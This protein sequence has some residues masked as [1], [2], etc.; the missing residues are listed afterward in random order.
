MLGG[1]QMVTQSPPLAVPVITII[2]PSLRG[3]QI[4]DRDREVHGC[5]R[6]FTGPWAGTLGG[7]PAQVLLLGREAY[8]VS[9]ASFLR[10]Q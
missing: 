2:D 1:P 10:G 7:M 8:A 6:F 3:A 5:V 9:G 4:T